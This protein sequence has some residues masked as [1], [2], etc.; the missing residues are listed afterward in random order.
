MSFF[1]LLDSKV[2]EE[3]KERKTKTMSDLAYQEPP[4]EKMKPAGL[5]K[6]EISSGAW[7]TLDQHEKEMINIYSLGTTNNARDLYYD[8]NSHKGTLGN[9]F[10]Y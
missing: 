6:A 2:V 8:K 10:P 9:T 5:K 1:D 3:S 4:I 7:K